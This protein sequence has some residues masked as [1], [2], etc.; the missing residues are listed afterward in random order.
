M[1]ESIYYNEENEI[2]IS[3]GNCFPEELGHNPWRQ[4]QSTARVIYLKVKD[5][6]DTTQLLEITEIENPNYVL[7][8]I[9]LAA[10]F[11]DALVPTETEFGEAIRFSMPK[12]LEVAKTIQPKG[13]VV[14]YTDQTLSQSNNQV[15]V[16]I[17]RVISVLKTVMGVALSG[18]IITQLT[19][20]I[21][22]TFTNLNTQKDSAWVFWGKETS[23]QTNY[24]YNVMFAIQ[25]ETTGRVMM[26]VPIGFEIRVFTDKRTV[27]FLTTKDY[28]NYSVNIQTLRFAQPLID[29]RALSINDLSEALRSS[30]YLY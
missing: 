14:A 26:C 24:T 22:D 5:P 1:K 8:A 20:A 9:Q 12:G 29:S 7:Q 25:N 6:I 3:Q 28:A 21:T 17:D 11:Q 18:S 16:M 13:A 30:K 19:A 4:P 27:L 10:A 23:H 15:S 2:Q